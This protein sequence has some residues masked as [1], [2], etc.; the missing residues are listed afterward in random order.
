M[1]R[2]IVFFSAKRDCDMDAIASGLSIL[3]R[4]P[5]V[6]RLEVARNRKT[7]PLSSEVDVVVYGEFEDE[8]ALNA[9]KSHPLYEES[10]RRVRPLR[11]LRIAAHYDVG[12]ARGPV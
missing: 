8:A 9:Y 5:H 10:I 11:E 1:I 4:I 2:H 7:D 3:T 6:T 12:D